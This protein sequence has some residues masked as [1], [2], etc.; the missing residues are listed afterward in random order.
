MVYDSISLIDRLIQLATVRERN[1]ERFFNNFIEPVYRDGEQIAKDYLALLAELQSR[2]AE[3]RDLRDLVNWLELKRTTL[4]PLR[5]KVRAL[6]DGPAIVG[7]S[8]RVNDNVVL[9]ERGLWG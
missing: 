6:V 8:K 9:F 4:Q 5:A 7:K 2:I 1:R 3:A